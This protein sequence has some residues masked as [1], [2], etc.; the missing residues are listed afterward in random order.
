MNSSSGSGWRHLRT[1]TVPVEVFQIP[2]RPKTY[3][4]DYNIV[5]EQVW[6]PP[7][8][9]PSEKLE[10]CAA[11][12][13]FSPELDKKTDGWMFA[14]NTFI[15]DKDKCSTLDNYQKVKSAILS[16]H[17]SFASQDFYADINLVKFKVPVDRQLLSLV[18]N[19]INNDLFVMHYH[20]SSLI[21]AQWQCKSC[22]KSVICINLHLL[23]V[24]VFLICTGWLEKLNPC[25]HTLTHFR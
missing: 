19:I 1:G 12:R 8:P 4:M 24:K 20:C 16:F 21:M 14:Q 9:P 11:L 23:S 25:D 2:G 22:R 5:F 7:P 3:R 18:S 6:T 15:V 17:S 10:V 13:L